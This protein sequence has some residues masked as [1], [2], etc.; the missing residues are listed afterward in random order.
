MK[1]SKSRTLTLAGFGAAVIAITVMLGVFAYTRLQTIE[2]TARSLTTD[3][4]PSIYLIGELRDTI[5]LR[6]TL[7]TDR[8]TTDDEVESLLWIMRSMPPEGKSMMS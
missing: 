5:L 6:Y 3:Y 4:L 8:V 2:G 7:L 1:A